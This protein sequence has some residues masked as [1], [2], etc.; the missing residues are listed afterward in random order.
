MESM[1]PLHFGSGIR[2]FKH[3]YMKRMKCDFN[4]PE[5]IDWADTQ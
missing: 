1:P 4:G 3:N 2:V 5:Y